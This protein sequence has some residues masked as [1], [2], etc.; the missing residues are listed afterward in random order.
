MRLWFPRPAYEAFPFLPT[1]HHVDGIGGL[2]FQSF[3]EDAIHPKIETATAVHSESK[4]LYAH[5]DPW[6]LDHLLDQGQQS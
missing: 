4:I 3:V 5:F 6:Q 1:D 2:S